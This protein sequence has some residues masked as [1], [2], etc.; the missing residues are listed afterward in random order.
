LPARDRPTPLNTIV[1]NESEGP[2]SR[3]YVMTSIQRRRRW[4]TAEKARF[5]EYTAQSGMSVTYVARRAGIA[6]SQL[7]ARKRRMAEGDHRAVEADEDVVGASKVREL[8]KRVRDLERLLGK[9][10]K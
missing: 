8:E 5:I 4:S 9:K 3:V 6:S 1:S 10:T 2:I 7:F